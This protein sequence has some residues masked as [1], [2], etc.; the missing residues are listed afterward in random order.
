MTVS[1]DVPPEAVIAKSVLAGIAEHYG[2]LPDC[3][4]RSYG[5]SQIGV[6]PNSSFFVTSASRFT[7]ATTWGRL[8]II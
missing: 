4:K 8:C 3:V 2:G 5:A 6:W 7:P 1:T